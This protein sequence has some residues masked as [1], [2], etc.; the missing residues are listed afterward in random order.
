MS[1][2]L[3][4]HRMGD[5]QLQREA[6]S[7]GVLDTAGGSPQLTQMVM[8]ILVALTVDSAYLCW[9]ME[10][11]STMS[12]LFCSCCSM[13]VPS[14]LAFSPVMHASGRSSAGAHAHMGQDQIS[15]CV[16]KRPMHNRCGSRNADVSLCDRRHAAWQLPCDQ[17]GSP[18]YLGEQSHQARRAI[19]ARF[20]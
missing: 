20:P 3:Y 15:C 5:V 1:I 18:A 8:K 4:V 2:Y 19:E 9:F 13:S 16:A 14:P 7:T 11:G 12:L 10:G 17:G 6:E